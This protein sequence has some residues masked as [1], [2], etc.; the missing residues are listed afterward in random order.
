VIV[1]PTNPITGVERKFLADAFLKKTTRWGHDEVIRPVDQ[2][3]DSPARRKFSDEVLKRSVE[4]VKN[5][6]QQGI[7][8][9]R[10]LPPPE[11]DGDE[12]IVKYVLKYSGA[13]GYISGSA[14]L[15]GA[16]LVAVQ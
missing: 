6:W 1:H 10:A 16:K 7:F 5:Y 9:G 14:D 12:E 2:N 13:I 8:S 15:N 3:A 4:A 11:L